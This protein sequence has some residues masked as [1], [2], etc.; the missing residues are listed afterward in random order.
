M[1]PVEPDGPVE[2]PTPPEATRPPGFPVLSATVPLL[3]GA[4]L[5]F[6]TRSLLT[7][8]FVL[9][10]F[11]FVVAG[12]L[13]SRRESRAE[14]RFR[15]AEFRRRLD[16][17]GTE[18]AAASDQAVATASEAAP[19]PRELAGWLPDLGPRIWERC[20]VGPGVLRVRLGTVETTVTEPVHHVGGRSDLRDEVRRIV[21]AATTRVLPVT[22]DL[23]DV[24]TIAVIG[25]DEAAVAV[26]RS[27]VAQL[28]TLVGPD[29]LGI[30]T[31]AGDARSP[32]WRWCSWLPHSE[33]TARPRRRLVVA[34]GL[35]RPAIDATLA[36][37]AADPG[38]V[39]VIVGTA[40][41]MLPPVGAV[42][43]V[44]G[45]GPGQPGGRLRIG[46]GRWVTVLVDD[47]V[48][49]EAESM[50]RALA[51]LRPANRDHGDGMVL[52]AR[53][54]LA[55]LVGSMSV[56]EVVE[57][58][59][60]IVPAGSLAAPIGVS[61]G[62]ILSVDL[63]RD[64]PH[65]LVAGTT[66]AGKSEMLRTLIGSLSMHHPP[67]RL[68]FML[69]DYKGGSAFRSLSA[70]PHTVGLVT[71]LTPML[72]ERALVSLRSEVRRR[73]S[74]LACHAPRG[75]TD[76]TDVDPAE[77]P[78]ALVVVVDE[79]ATL[80]QEVP[81]F[82]D[83]M[84]DIA[85]RGRSLGIHMI[86]ATQR[87][88]GVVT[89]A[90]RANTGLRIALR[91]A[92][93]DD[94]RDVV[95]GPAASHLPRE[96]P[97]R[98]IVRVGP[99]RSLPFQAAYSTGPTGVR[100]RV[101]SAP[102]GHPLPPRP[103]SS[104]R[105]S[106]LD[107]LVTSVQAAH[108][109]RAGPAPR[110]P[111]LEPLPEQLGLSEIGSIAVAPTGWTVTLGRTDRPAE[112]RQEDF[113]V[114]LTRGGILV[115]GSPGSGRS[116][117]LH[118]IAAAVTRSLDD[119]VEIHAIDAARGL[120]ALT[121]I[122]RVGAVIPADDVERVLRLLRHLDG[123]MRRR[124]AGH[125]EGPDKRM[126]LIDGAGV[127]DDTYSRI[128]G[129]EGVELLTRLA[130]EGRSVG[131]SVAITATRR[132]EL[133]PA[134]LAGLEHRIVLRSNPDDAVMLGVPSDVAE[135]RPGPG[136]A[137]S[138]GA[139]VQIA[140]AD[141]TRGSGDPTVRHPEREV[142]RPPER[143]GVWA[144]PR[145][146]AVVPWSALSAA[147]ERDRPWRLPIGL[148]GDDLTVTHLDLTH[149]SAVVAGPPRSGR[150]TT[151]DVIARAAATAGIEHRIL[152]RSVA[153]IARRAGNV[154]RRAHARGRH[155]DRSGGGRPP[156]SPLRS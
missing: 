16:E 64:G 30:E 18:L 19:T 28:A 35:A 79:F 130:S 59:E 93:P 57:R 77:R 84:V 112:Q 137:W 109:R 65:V 85:Q 148:D 103:K 24:G 110:R 12:A 9:F 113:A 25:P 50:A 131:I 134:I 67:E 15:V 126:L 22:L 96:I 11:V 95:D 91:V 34:D 107:A 81:A 83:G 48:P 89:D 150:S 27:F 118:T 138:G 5:W 70:L 100:S 94:S 144:V 146:P 116:T 143:P 111:W 122:E 53:V 120:R 43:E 154:D 40:T 121:D 123:E 125:R 36:E 44:S 152:A 21:R 71:D 1:S 74:T 37:T 8:A 20:A 141:E 51:G 106:Q 101:R 149:H 72:A 153:I 78:P 124:L 129:G 142:E 90:I 117:T 76:I 52:P 66:G 61:A 29:L 62:G 75:A 2:V 115:I 86:L 73:E 6:A 46:D 82:V 127:F 10:S 80:A 49:D 119:R 54:E 14:E 136:R 102:L 92:D 47:V 99:G 23:D 108:A 39:A 133:S 42:V 7:A 104:N 140:V 38:A 3:M 31:V 68:T 69:V 13:E 135:S 60:R 32:L 56:D 147:F 105:R 114:D 55:D 139:V 26:A 33:P 45:R 4:A 145:L 87:P 132:A 155:L 98:G 58:W 88:A 63:P 17:A 156:R 41:A 97:G 128:N 151:L